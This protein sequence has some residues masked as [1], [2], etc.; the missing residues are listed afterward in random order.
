[1]SD[2]EHQSVYFHDLSLRMIFRVAFYS[3]LGLAVLGG[4]G[5]ILAA[6]FG[7]NAHGGSAV[8]IVLIVLSGVVMIPLTAAMSAVW[9]VV[10][11]A[12]SQPILRRLGRGKLDD[13]ELVD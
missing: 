8:L 10:G 4:I 1:M 13:M 7:S 6:V 9:L 3:N 5:F 2:G 12:L 11:A